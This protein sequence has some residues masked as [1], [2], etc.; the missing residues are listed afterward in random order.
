MGGSAIDLRFLDFGEDSSFQNLCEFT[1]AI[2][3]FIGLVRM[4]VT[5]ADVQLRGDSVSALTWAQTE[6][7]RGTIVTNAAL[8]FRM[9]AVAYGL[10][11]KSTTHI[12]GDQNT[13]CDELSQ[14]W[15]SGEEISGVLGRHNLVGANILDLNCDPNVQQLL[16]LCSP[17]L[18]FESEDAYLC[19]WGLIRDAIQGMAH[20]PS[21]YHHQY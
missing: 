5:N 4:G 11:V 12:P 3:G 6:R 10:D 18:S 8:V 19:H 15:E 20:P 7:Y 16:R 17:R 13:R 9:L 2:L 21:Q 1:G 14:L